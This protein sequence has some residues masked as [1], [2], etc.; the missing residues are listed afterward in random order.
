[1]SEW[2]KSVHDAAGSLLQ[3]NG[4]SRQC[5]LRMCIW[6]RW[7]CRWQPQTGPLEGKEDPRAAEMQLWC[8]RAW[9]LLQR[10]SLEDHTSS[11]AP[12]IAAPGKRLAL[13]EADS[14]LALG[15]ISKKNDEIKTLWRVNR[16]EFDSQLWRVR[17]FETLSSP[18]F[19]SGEGKDMVAPEHPRNRALKLAHRSE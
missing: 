16:S 2:T 1:M 14:R 12:A 17:F 5:P 18:V 6:A 4:N 15:K 8:N 11:V 7:W 19:L 3:A 13:K 9:W 10:T